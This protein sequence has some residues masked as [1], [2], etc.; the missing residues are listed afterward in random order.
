M[1]KKRNQEFKEKYPYIH[2]GSFEVMHI[3]DVIETIIIVDIWLHSS[4]FSIE[5]MSG[6]CKQTLKI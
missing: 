4:T 3:D 5:L 1:P 2:V 6:D